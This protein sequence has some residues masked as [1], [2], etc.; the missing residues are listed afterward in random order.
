MAPGCIICWWRYSRFAGLFRLRFESQRFHHLQSELASAR[1]V[2][3]SCLPEPLRTGPISLSYVYEPMQQIGGDLLFLHPPSA[4]PSAALSAVMLD[5]TGHGIAAAL[6]V[7]RLFGELRRL[8]AENPTIAPRQVL[9]ALNHYVF[10]T[11][12]EYQIYATAICIRADADQSSLEYASGGHPTAFLRRATGQIEELPS[13]ALLLGI[14]DDSEYESEPAQF[15]FL[16]GDA[17][18]AYTDGAAEAISPQGHMLA[19]NGMRQLTHEI[20]SN[21]APFS[22]WP[23]QILS[24]IVS[25]R[26]APAED[27]TLIL[28]IYRAA[29]AQM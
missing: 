28:A 25:H 14:Q 12:A 15:A 17:L 10:L 1:K 29:S 2:H 13:T 4:K 19:T 5:V 22:T 24:R 9:A 26:S 11:L 27:D 21:G 6:T 8:F 7:N 20:T 3:E 23:Q 16:P 18:I